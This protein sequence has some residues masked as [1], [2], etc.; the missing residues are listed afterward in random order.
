MARR[1]LDGNPP[2]TTTF[3]QPGFGY[4]GKH[5]GYDYGVKEWTL[6]APE[7]GTILNVY[8]GRENVDGGN[9]I[10]MRGAHGDHRFLHL[11]SIS[12]ERG[13]QVSEGQAMGVTGSTGNVGYHLHHDVRKANSGWTD[14]LS[15]YFDWESIIKQGDDMADIANSGDVKNQYKALLHR[16]ATQQDIDVYVGPDKQVTFKQLIEAIEA[17]PEF[18]QVQAGLGDAKVLSPGTYKVN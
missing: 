13:Q 18:A 17:S 1:A 3:L 11:K 14:S 10:E 16:E 15:N 6:K 4:F 12:V 9:I 7:A 5:A 2:I 8:R